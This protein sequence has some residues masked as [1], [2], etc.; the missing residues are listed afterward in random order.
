VH[1][2]PGAMS[3]GSSCFNL[4]H[5]VCDRVSSLLLPPPSRRAYD[6]FITCKNSKVYIIKHYCSM[7]ADRITLPRPKNVA[8]LNQRTS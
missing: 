3:I 5:A 6:A 8:S 2:W 4:S 7:Q 1:H